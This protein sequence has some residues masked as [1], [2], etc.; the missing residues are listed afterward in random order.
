MKTN[1]IYKQLVANIQG[2]SPE[3]KQEF[4][5]MLKRQIL[6]D[7]QGGN[8]VGAI[9]EPETMGEFLKN[10]AGFDD[11][12][13]N[14]IIH[15]M[16]GPSE[17]SQAYHENDIILITGQSGI[18]KTHLAKKIH[19]T[20]NPG[21]PFIIINAA[22][23]KPEFH[24]SELF[25]VERGAYTGAESDKDGAFVQAGNG[26]L[27]IDELQSLSTEMQGMLNVALDEKQVTKVGPSNIKV[28]YKCKLIF[29]SNEDLEDLVSTNK[30]RGDLFSRLTGPESH[31]IDMGHL[32]KDRIREITHQELDRLNINISPEAENILL[33]IEYDYGVRELKTIIANA[34]RNARSQ[35]SG[36]ILPDHIEGERA[37]IE[38][39]STE[40]GEH[41][42]GFDPDT[43][44]YLAKNFTGNKLDFPLDRIQRDRISQVFEEIGG[45]AAKMDTWLRKGNLGMVIKHLKSPKDLSRTS[46]EMALKEVMK[47]HAVTEDDVVT[48][49]SRIAKILESVEDD[50][51][52]SLLPE[53][54][55]TSEIDDPRIMEVMDNTILMADEDIIG[56]V[57]HI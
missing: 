21:T 15:A 53:E 5:D 41:F 25:G 54:Q 52:K 39:K 20:A 24:G 47:E 4:K 51:F 7:I 8:I 12:T 43:M 10:V 46:V 22:T 17:Q 50:P 2:A 57:K 6:K 11:V 23:L 14:Q 45:D 28:P 27:F 42:Q 33:N 26:T 34:A 3:D 9:K 31:H 32:S 18:G 30:F 36:T 48:G 49:M 1:M 40:I 37:H 35:N 44:R 55:E 19:Q 16:K 56:I 29:A 13:I 38:K